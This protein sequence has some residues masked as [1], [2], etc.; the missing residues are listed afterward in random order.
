M[1][2]NGFLFETTTSGVEVLAST[3]HEWESGPID[4]VVT[5]LTQPDEIEQLKLRT[6]PWLSCLGALSSRRHER[7]YSKIVKATSCQLEGC[8]NNNT[9]N[10][11]QGHLVQR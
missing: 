9:C 10:Y 2:R 7:S 5:L 1:S 11:L 6:H 8:V 3:D 4:A